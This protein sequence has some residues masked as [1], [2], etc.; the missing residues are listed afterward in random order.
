MARVLLTLIA[1]YRRFVS[2]LLGATCRYH[3]SCS[4]YGASCIERFGVARGVWLGARRIA[5]CH[6]WHAGGFD[7]V[8][9]LRVTERAARH[10]R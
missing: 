1:G 10:G 8:P 5:R 6:P 7:P 3:P 4:A 2:P 9:E